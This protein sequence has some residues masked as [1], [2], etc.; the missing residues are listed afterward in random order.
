MLA[1]GLR[2]G[3]R[4]GRRSIREGKVLLREEW[5]RYLVGKT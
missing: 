5:E 4:V 2:N 3:M 1:F